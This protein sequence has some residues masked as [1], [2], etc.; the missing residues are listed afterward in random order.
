[1][2]NRSG[3]RR[4]LLVVAST[5]PSRPDDGTPAFVRDLAWAAAREFDTTVLVPRVRGARTIEQDG[6]LRVVRFPYFPSRWEDLAEGAILE[7]LRDRRRRWLQV[8]PFFANEVLAIWRQVRGSRP[9]LLHLH[10]IVPQGVSALL[11]AR[12]VPWVVTTLG[13]D[14]YA[15]QSPPMRWLKRTVLR[16]AR[17]VTAMNADM[18]RRLVELGAPTE[19]TYVM[20]M[21]ADVAGLRQK[22]QALEQAQGRILFVGR[23]VEKKGAEILLR[24]V[25]ALPPSLQWSLVVVGDGPLRRN[26]ERQAT[27]L[28]VE[29]RGQ[30]SR[31][32]LANELAAC[33]VVAVPSVPARSGDQ[34]GLPVALL[35][36]MASGRPVVASR[37]PGLDMAIEDEKT[38]LLVTPGDVDGLADALERL[39][40]DRELRNRLGAAAAIRAEDFSIESQS[41]RYVQL[42]LDVL[43]AEASTT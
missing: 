21:G 42:Y 28:P 29:F 24:A 39:L 8:L 14:V 7:N 25:R 35:E 34:D 33:E 30:L 5:Y 40:R 18:V 3:A 13:G 16:R 9:D 38:G 26:L 10:W 17:A 4:K 12:R 20:P 43:A 11:A 32:D 19:H 31:A 22:R 1:M 27:G 36:A 6:P 41:R 37:L 2:S 23:L 15:M